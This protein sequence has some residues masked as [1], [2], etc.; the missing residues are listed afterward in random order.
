MT[1]LLIL[2]Y[3]LPFLFFQWFTSRLDTANEHGVLQKMVEAMV[4]IHSARNTKTEPRKPGTE[5]D[6]AETIK[7]IRHLSDPLCH[8]FVQEEAT[9]TKDGRTSVGEIS[10]ADTSL[11]GKTYLSPAEVGGIVLPLSLLLLGLSFFGIVK[12]LRL[13]LESSIK[14]RLIAFINRD[15]DSPLKKYLHGYLRILIGAGITV[16]LQSSSIFTSTLVPM[17]GTG[18]IEVDSIYP[19]FLGSNLGTTVSTFVAALAVSQYEAQQKAALQAALI[20]FFFNLFGV[21]IFYPLP[22]MR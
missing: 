3:L 13:L 19:L 17:A 7:F 15:F 4:K 9:I 1:F 8:F 6:R 22:F 11:F 14:D 5:E 16:L 21:L 2:I 20:H 12:L 18:I 10:V